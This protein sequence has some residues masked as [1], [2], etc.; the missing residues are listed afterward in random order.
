MDL[1][2]TLADARA[3]QLL[4]DV[5]YEVVETGYRHPTPII[6]VRSRTADGTSRRYRVEGFWPYFHI[7][8]SAFATDPSGTLNDR[9]VVGVEADLR[10]ADLDW[11]Q[12]EHDLPDDPALLAT[13]LTE[14]TDAVVSHD[15]ATACSITD[16]PTARVIVREP[17]DVVSKGAGG[18]ALRDVYDR[19]FE[20]DI[21]F[22]RRFLISTGIYQ[23]FRGP[24]PA[25]GETMTVRMENWSPGNSLTQDL[26]P[27]EA[28]DVPPRVCTFDIEVLTYGGGF[29]DASRAKNEISAITAHDNY[30]DTYRV[31]GLRGPDWPDDATAIEQAVAERTE[32]FGLSL[33][34][35]DITIYDGETQM[36]DSFHEWMLAR[37]F[38]MVTGWNTDGFDIP[39]IIQRSYNVQSFAIKDWVRTGNPGV[40]VEH[41]TGD[42]VIS[43]SLQDISTLDML[44]AYRKT[45]YRELDSY[46]LDSVA[47]AELGFG[48]VEFA[49]DELDAAWR[50]EPVEFLA[51]NARDVQAVVGIEREAGLLDLYANLRELTGGLW[52]TCNNNGPMLDTLFCRRAYESGYVLPTNVEPDEGVYHGARVFDPKPGVHRN[53][54]YP[55]LSSMY[56]SL[57][58]MMNLGTDTIVG[59]DDALAESSYTEADCYRFPVDN[60]PFAVVPKGE[61]Y[62]SVDRIEY[63][64]VK[65][66]DG[67]LR[68]MFD[69]QVEWEWVL[70]PTVK[71]SFIRETIDELIELKYQYT[72]ELYSAVKRVTNSVY[73]VMG[74]SDSA[75]GK[76]FRLYDR[77]VAEGI[78]IAGRQVITMTAETLTSY[79]Q[80]TYDSEAYIVGGDTDSAVTSIPNAPTL[81]ATKQWSDEGIDIVE[82]EYDTFVQ[83]MYRFAP[84]DAHQLAVELEN[85]SSTLF[86]MA[87]SD[88]GTGAHHFTPAADAGAVKKRYSEHLVW[89]DD[90]GWLDTP[91]ADAY[92]GGSDACLAD[93]ADLSQLKYESSVTYATYETV[94][95]EYDPADNI[96][97]TGFEYVR[98]DSATITRRAQKRV[99]TDLLLAP[100]PRDRIEPYLRQLWDDAIAGVVP[101]EELA[102]PKGISKPLDEYGYKTVAELTDD[103]N[104]D[105]TDTDRDYGGRYI[106]TPSPTYRGA[107][108]ATA[109]IPHEELGEGSKPMRVYI[110]KVRGDRYPA[111][112]DYGGQFPTDERPDPPECGRVVDAISVA[113]PER[114]PASFVPDTEKMAEKELRGKVEPIVNTMGFDW[115]DLVT[116]GQQM[117]FGAF[118]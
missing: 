42:E 13:V 97:I 104:Y 88:S 65:T 45:Q 95:A 80:T 9:R 19:T 54:V 101:V 83:E 86:Y 99:L 44:S 77:K 28:P 78:T 108:Y 29:P 22:V 102:R 34:A 40:W 43:Y 50:D 4:T 76:G 5:S 79:L 89:D 74:D 26:V 36:L 73:G 21:P 39:Y 62:A 66:P 59:G 16:E 49:G 24:T 58:S 114:I 32:S 17:N 33:D 75:G 23:G 55:D 82:Q 51:Y 118:Q 35:D 96:D 90:A 60:R 27:D 71:E 30:E 56:P 37:E 10:A 70:K 117:T 63:K 92:P 18:S 91:T 52:S 98:S 81:D 111:A 41:R 48:K 94:L 87:D 57:F 64:G 53:C 103:E 100:D 105:V 47:E 106:S 8:L 38:D 6:Y 107:K 46:T 2:S 113:Y 14:S 110:E 61:S 68:E 67:S 93:E 15:P 31:W 12:T 20:A 25:P 84:D 11:L 112:Y 115:D 1:S 69:M 116:D 85:V 109:N 72:G 3:Q 7:P